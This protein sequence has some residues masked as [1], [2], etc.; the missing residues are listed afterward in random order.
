M[1]LPATIT[2]AF[3]PRIRSWRPIG[4]LT[5]R[6]ASRPNRSA[7]LPQP[8]WGGSVTSITAEPMARR[9][10]GGA[11]SPLVARSRESGAPARARPAGGQATHP[12]VTGSAPAAGGAWRLAS[13]PPV[14]VSIVVDP[15]RTTAVRLDG[16]S[17]RYQRRVRAIGRPAAHRTKRRWIGDCAAEDSRSAGYGFAS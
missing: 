2:L 11:L 1:I 10:P 5:K 6:R 14:D 8:R 16:L 13:L 4:E 7:N 3:A 15:A 17:S 12:A 9:E